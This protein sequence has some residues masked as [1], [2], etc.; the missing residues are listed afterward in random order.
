MSEQAGIQVTGVDFAV[1]MVHG[2]IGDRYPSWGEAVEAARASIKRFEYKGHV[3]RPGSADFHPRR[4][5]Q[6]FDTLVIYSRAF[7]HMR[8]TEPVQARPESMVR[9]G[10]D[11]VAATWEVFHDGTAEEMERA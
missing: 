1:P 8:V 9:S 10:Q 7:V 6:E 3:V 5:F 2:T 4:H 11:R